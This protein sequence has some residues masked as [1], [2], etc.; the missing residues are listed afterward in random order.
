MSEQFK[1]DMQEFEFRAKMFLNKRK[2]AYRALILFAFLFAGISVGRFVSGSYSINDL[3]IFI[4]TIVISTFIGI[5]SYI[6][7][8]DSQKRNDFGMEYNELRFNYIMQSI[9][10]V[11]DKISSMCKNSDDNKSAQKNGLHSW[12]SDLQEYNKVNAKAYFQMCYRD[13]IGFVKFFHFRKNF[14]LIINR[15]RFHVHCFY[16]LPWS[17]YGNGKISQN[18]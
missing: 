11:D 1:R 17:S 8:W 4:D 2:V 18:L 12:L 16:D 9:K 6:L 5:V 13:F 3:T 14:D 15:P 10:I 7:G